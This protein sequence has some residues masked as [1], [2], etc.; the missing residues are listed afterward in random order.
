M[1][2]FRNYYAILGVAKE[3]SGDEIKRAFRRLARQYH[4]DL[5]PGNKEAEER[6]KDIGEAY[7]VLSDTTK[8]AQYDEYSKFWKQKGFQNA[9][10]AAAGRTWGDRSESRVADNLDYSEFIDFN[11][12][13][14]RL[15]NRRGEP[16]APPQPGNRDYYRPGTTRTAY[17]VKPP[18][19]R[20]AEARLTI[21]LEKAFSGGRER[22]RL[23]DGRSLEVNMPPGLVTGQRIRLKNQGINGGDLFLKITVAPHDFFRLEGVDLYCEVPV[24]PSEAVLGSAIEVPTLDGMVKMNLPRGVRHGQRLRLSNKGY[25]INRDRRGDQIVEIQ[26]ATPTQ[27]STDELALYEQLRAIESFDPR[28]NLPI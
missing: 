25:P 28:A 24:T 14:D 22:I 27:L 18:V 16:T 12:F 11:S 2:N 13:V 17:T 10:R 5:N 9:R 6:F 21:P 26:I 7:E 1:Q 4:P 3:A 23:E 20:D 19:A 8:R 15:L